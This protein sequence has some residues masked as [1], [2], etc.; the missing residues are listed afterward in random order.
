VHSTTQ[1]DWILIS[2]YGDASYKENPKIWKEIK[3]LNAMGA[4]LYCIGDFNVIMD[5]TEKWEGS[6]RL[7]P[8]SV[9]FRE[10]LFDTGLIDL[11]FKVPT[12]TWTNK[13][14]SSSAVH[15]RLDR[16]VANT[17][18]CNFFQKHTSTTYRK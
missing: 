4:L 9:G 10:F 12:Y 2:I 15:V 18:W 5:I 7:N 17:S 14:N 1:P 13:P 8:N 11:G 3:D 16:V 6:Q